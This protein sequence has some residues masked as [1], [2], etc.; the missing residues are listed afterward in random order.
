MQNDLKIRNDCFV[1]SEH[2]YSHHGGICVFLKRPLK[3]W[4]ILLTV[5]SMMVT[6]SAVFITSYYVNRQSLE[7]IVLKENQSNAKKL[8]ILTNDTF[9]SMEA[10]LQSQHQNIINHWNN[11]Q[12]LTE[13][14]KT[15]RQSNPNFNSVTIIDAKGFGKAND[16][17]LK[18]VGNP[19][20]TVGIKTGLQLKKN[21][22]SSPYIGVNKKLMMIVSTALYHNG[23]YYGMVNGLV[24]LQE[25]NF[26]TRLLKETYGNDNQSV[27]VY[28]RSGE[29]VY[30]KES[31]LIGTLMDKNQAH[32]FSDESGSGQHVFTES[33]GSR[34]FTGFAI[35]PKNQWTILSMTPEV[36]AIAPAKD[37]TIKAILTALAFTSLT[38]ILLIG[39]ILFITKPLKQLSDLD[40]QKPIKEIVHD[41]SSIPSSYREVNNIKKMILAFASD[42]KELIQSLEKNA[43]TDPM[44]GIANRR[45]LDDLV[46]FIQKNKEPFGYVLLDID[47]FKKVNDT[48]GHLVGDQV[49]IRLAEL[50][51]ECTLESGLPV[52]IGGEE[53]AI[54]LQ[55]V[56][57]ETVFDFAESLRIRVENTT[58]PNEMNITISVGAGYMDCE[59]YN[60]ETFFHDVDLQLYKAKNNGRNRVEKIWVGNGEKITS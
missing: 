49:L 51:V 9:K 46:D 55:N 13:I 50:M 56:S 14:M 47:F 23:R 28:D 15:L 39:L 3:F 31:S 25:D 60:L 37:A 6:L 11:P 1:I 21:F 54:I 18:L 24:W 41:I 45:R 19:V 44:T 22:I 38:L 58:F 10:S 5:V 52:R 27:A 4:I 34:I 48:H 32:L 59:N 57:K 29:Y 20:K 43:V 12:Q 8:S 17:D 42:Q 16:P 30:L 53:F 36:A 35:V 40:Y 7:T 2:R 26:L 33:T